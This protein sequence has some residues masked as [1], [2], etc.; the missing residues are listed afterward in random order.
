AEVVCRNRV[1]RPDYT[2]SDAGSANE[3][4]A[5]L[6]KQLGT[7]LLEPLEGDHLA[8]D[9]HRPGALHPRQT[10]SL[11]ARP[12]RADGLVHHEHLAPGRQ[13]PEYRLQHADVGFRTADDELP[14]LA[15]WQ[16]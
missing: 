10:Q 14:A 4:A 7:C 6:A 15:A 12:A 11:V 8:R 9:D 16:V 3:S 1:V 5:D 2:R 13:Q